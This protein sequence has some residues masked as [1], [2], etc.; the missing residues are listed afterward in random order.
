MPNYKDSSSDQGVFISL[1]PS[2]QTTPGSFDETIHLLIGHVLDLSVFEAEYDNDHGGAPAYPPS[3]LLKIILAAY[4]RGVTGSRKIENL[5]K[6]HT[7]FMAL[8]GFLTPDHSTITAFISKSPERLES[9]FLQ[10]VLEC[11]YLGLTGGEVFAIDG[12][13]ISSNASKDWSGTKADFEKKYK[14]IRRAIRRML[15]RHRDED[16]AQQVDGEVREREEKQIEKLRTIAGKL[17]QPIEEMEDKLG[18]S[19]RTKK[20]NLTDNDSAHMMSGGSGAKQGYMA[21]ANADKQRQ[22]I[23]AADITGDTEQNI[24]RPMVEQLKENLDTDLHDSKLLADAGFHTGGN[25]DYCHEEAIDAYIADNKFRK[26]DPRFIDHEDKKPASRKRRYFRSED[27]HYNE[28]ENRCWCPAGKELWLS[29]N[30]YW[31]GDAYY[32]K[33]EGYLNDCKQCSLQAQCMRRGVKD[34][35]RQVSIRKGREENLPRPLALMKE[36][37]DSVK[38]RITYSDRIGIIEPVFAHIK[39]TLGLNWLSLRGRN[40]VKGQWLLWCMIHNMEKN[41]EIWR[42]RGDLGLF[43]PL[44]LFIEDNQIVYYP[45]GKPSY[46]N[47][48]MVH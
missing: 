40:K 1:V 13:K 14:K 47:V 18:R 22:V 34:R 33:F 46:L 41:T 35:G 44:F 38:G 24:F 48:H 9:L 37:I 17:K 27:F 8:S 28:E 6:Y 7:T 23:C 29:S 10:I 11:D 16:L 45:D 36:K 25:V 21:M 30:R 12:S 32:R 20:S 26:R 5:C 43:L 31:L 2:E 15:K 4:Y 19:G 39:H 42:V 3:A